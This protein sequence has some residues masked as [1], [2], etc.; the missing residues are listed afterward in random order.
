MTQIDNEKEAIIV[1]LKYNS[2]LCRSKVV[3]EVLKS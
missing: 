3:R 1:F 2:N